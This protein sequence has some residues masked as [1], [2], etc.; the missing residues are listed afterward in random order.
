MSSNV[1]TKTTPNRRPTGGPVIDTHAHWFPTEWVEL[2]LKDG[3]ANGAETGRNAQGNVTFR[4]P[5]IRSDFKPHY[6]DPEIRLEKMNGQGVDVQAL[7]LTQP[8]V[9]WAPPAFGLALSQCYN[10]NLSRV[11]H[12]YPG[13]FVGMAS[14]P[15]QAPELAV[16]ELERVA[17][18]P[19]I[20][21]AY[22][23]THVNGKNLDEKEFWPVYAKCEALGWPIFLHSL[24]PL[25]RD[26][27]PRYYLQNF[28]GNP[29]ETG[30]AAA[31][32]MFGGVMDEF[33][34]L[35]VMLPHAGGTFPWL[36]GR[37]A[38][39]ATVRKEVA[40][41]K[42][43][44]WEYRR[45][46]HYDTIGHRAEIIRQLIRQVGADRVVLGSDHPADMGCVEPVCEI[47]ELSDLP[48]GDR[49]LILGG[50]AARMLGV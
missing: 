11:F 2:L 24:N 49:D 1:G 28:L 33:P 14:L 22:L 31:S 26:R 44:P 43:S 48:V 32:L 38:H 27:M 36:L 41:M 17:K 35:E 25:G 37:M 15:M 42:R 20:R 12:R 45:R 8:M 30:I 7:S 34:R 6:I 40:H 9:Y 10:D 50:T 21:G 23:G 39:G 16:R 47:E 46:F 29:Y 18:L 5:G 13:R 19:G 3:P 4:V